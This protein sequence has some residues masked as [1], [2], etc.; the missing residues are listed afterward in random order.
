MARLKFRNAESFS[1][2]GS[3]LR[4]ETS[5]GPKPASGPFT[6]GKTLGRRNLNLGIKGCHADL[7]ARHRTAS[8]LGHVWRIFGFRFRENHQSATVEPK[9]R[10]QGTAH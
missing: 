7:F 9:S 10:N 6:P 5:P 3:S 1:K 2:A 8:K 4:D